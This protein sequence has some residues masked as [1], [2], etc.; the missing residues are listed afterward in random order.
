M[1]FTEPN[2]VQELQGYIYKQEQGGFG[3]SL[4]VHGKGLRSLLALTKDKASSV[5]GFALDT[6]SDLHNSMQERTC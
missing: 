3:V 5:E 6:P 1:M 4:R 2:A